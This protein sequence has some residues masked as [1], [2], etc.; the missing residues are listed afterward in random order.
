MNTVIETIKSRRAIRAYA[1]T[2]IDHATLETILDAGRWAPS[3]MNRQP[4]RFVVAE[5]AAFRQKLAAAARPFY[6]KWLANLADDAR[7][8]IS[9]RNAAKPDPVYYGAAAVVFVIGNGPTCELDCPMVCVNM[10]LAARSLGLGSC[11]VY[12]GSLVAGDP[13]I[14]AAL[15]LQDG[16]RVFGPI[17]LGHPQDAFPPPT[18]RK[19]LAVKW[20]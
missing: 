14:K 10:M 13:T 8:R 19:P 16:E 18:E 5:S 20:L 15:E 9:E 6:D 1:A 17:V 11:W 4:Y 2:P 12:T 7:K 3:A